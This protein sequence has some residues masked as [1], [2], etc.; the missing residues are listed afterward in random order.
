MSFPSF[1]LGSVSHLTMTIQANLPA[2]SKNTERANVLSNI[3][4]I[5]CFLTVYLVLFSC[6]YQRESGR[7]MVSSDSRRL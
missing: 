6:I 3:G 7:S 1:P 5:G 4:S 2:G